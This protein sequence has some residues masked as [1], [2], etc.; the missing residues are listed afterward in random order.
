MLEINMSKARLIAE[1]GISV[2]LMIVFTY[3]LS[4]TAGPI[5]ISFSFVVLL[6]AGIR[7][8]A[9]PAAM[10]A[11]V[12]DLIGGAIFYGGMFHFGITFTATLTGF[13]Y[14]LLFY[15]KFEMKNLV[16]FV[17]FVVIGAHLFLQSLWLMQIYNLGY[18]ETILT[19]LASVATMGVIKV[20]FILSLAK[21]P[22]YE[23]IAKMN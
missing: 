2:A 6:V 21:S 10:I 12:S 3:L 1:M 18:L 7:L 13:L 19:R 20:I 22:W 9:V 17:I 14:G 11:A 8:G 15:K 5:R 16:F 23:R 4:F